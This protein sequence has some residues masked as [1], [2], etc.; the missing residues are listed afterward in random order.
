MKETNC[1]YEVTVTRSVISGNWDAET[2]T[3]IASC[4]NCREIV[5]VSRWMRSLARQS[6]LRPDLPAVEYIWWK[7]GLL[8]RQAA[9]KM[10]MRSI[11][12]TRVL[13][14][15]VFASGLGG[16][17]YCRWQEIQKEIHR[18]FGYVV[19]RADSNYAV[20]GRCLIALTVVLLLLNIALTLR[21]I[22]V[23]GRLKKGLSSRPQ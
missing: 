1:D 9:E 21:A 19:L 23:E 8:Q 2:Q 20:S 3:H 5:S 22:W 13:A 11:V 15:L 12:V 16:A 6:A 4:S 18:L 7:A 10:V 17:I 14:Y